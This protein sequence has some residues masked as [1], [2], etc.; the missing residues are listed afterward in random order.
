MIT[1]SPALN[2]SRRFAVPEFA[3]AGYYLPLRRSRYIEART[4]QREYGDRRRAMP[5]DEG[6]SCLTRDLSVPSPRLAIDYRI[7]WIKTFGVRFSALWPRGW[8]GLGVIL[9]LR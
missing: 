9:P 6:Y 7:A 3:Y 1:L 5:V 2:R 8:Q 4:W